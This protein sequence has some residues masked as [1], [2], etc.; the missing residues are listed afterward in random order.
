MLISYIFFSVIRILFIPNLTFISFALSVV[1]CS[2]NIFSIPVYINQKY[3]SYLCYRY[4]SLRL[5]DI[6]GLTKSLPLTTESFRNHVQQSCNEAARTIQM[7]WVPACVKIISD[8]REEVEALMPD[9][10]VKL[11]TKYL[12]HM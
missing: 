1:T 2:I 11:A 7:D 5:I 8:R 9:D 6:P 4:S 12:L 3:Y 10:E